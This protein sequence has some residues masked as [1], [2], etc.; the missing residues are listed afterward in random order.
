MEQLVSE[1]SLDLA[2]GALLR[3]AN[4][5]AGDYY[6]QRQQL[7]SDQAA[8]IAQA[9]GPVDLTAADPTRVQRLVTPEVTGRRVGMVQ[10]YRV[11]RQPDRPVEVVSVVDVVSPSMP[12]DRARAPVDPLAARVAAGEAATPSRTAMSLS[13]IAAGVFVLP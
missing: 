11:V 13:T 9:L 6:A 12:Q 3:S 1:H 4:F 7:V 10:V 2:R 8:R 5:I